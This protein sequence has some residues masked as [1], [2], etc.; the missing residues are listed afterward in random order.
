MEMR[1]T[2]AKV[3]TMKVVRNNEIQ[4]IFSSKVDRIC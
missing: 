3:L 4:D 1:I 2:L